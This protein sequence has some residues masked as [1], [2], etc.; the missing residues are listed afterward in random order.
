VSDDVEGR[1]QVAI[2]A[3]TVQILTRHRTATAQCDSDLAFAPDGEPL[4]PDLVTKRFRAFVEQVGLPPVRLHG[5]RH[6]AATLRSR[7]DGPARSSRSRTMANCSGGRSGGWTAIGWP[8]SLPRSVP[9]C[10]RRAT[11]DCHPPGC[12]GRPRGRRPRRPQRRSRARRV[13]GALDPIRGQSG[14]TRAR[15]LSCAA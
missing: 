12:P 14:N 9:A 4:V 10:R 13:S 7:A 11:R 2:D 15:R 8:S 3:G 6:G 5:L 1:R